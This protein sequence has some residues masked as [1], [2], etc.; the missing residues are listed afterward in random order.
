MVSVVA[1]RRMPQTRRTSALLCRSGIGPT[2]ALRDAARDG[3]GTGA[4]SYK[5]FHARDR[6]RLDP[7]TCHRGPSEKHRIPIAGALGVV[8]LSNDERRVPGCAGICE[9]VS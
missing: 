1:P 6:R 3:I 8:V 9:K 2:Y 4:F 5:G 7:R